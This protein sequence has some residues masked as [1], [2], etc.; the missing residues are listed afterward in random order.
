M[1]KQLSA[2][3]LRELLHY[4]HETG[5]FTRRV[6]VAHNAKA[7]D[8][9]GCLHSDGCIV[10][11]IDRRLYKAHGLAWL[12]MTGEVAAGDIDHKY[13]IRND[14]RWSELRPVSHGQNMQNQRRARVD[15]Q[16][17]MLGVSPSRG[18]WK[19]Q[20]KVDGKNKFIGR[21]DTPEAAHTA[22]L[23]AKVRLHPFQTLVELA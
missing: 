3:R 10:I 15:N 13:G 23:E 7:G 6:T 1:T 22:Y 8:V 9:A 2:E 20:I 16:V 4:D 14:N 19:A 21:F 12:Y 17:G 18:R 11:R 5:V